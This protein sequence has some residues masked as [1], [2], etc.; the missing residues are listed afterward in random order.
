MTAVSSQSHPPNQPLAYSAASHRPFFLRIAISFE[1]LFR[2]D[3]KL[4]CADSDGVCYICL[5][6]GVAN[7]V[8]SLLS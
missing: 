1:I 5:I 4:W 8:V 2:H 3:G 6:I 7:A